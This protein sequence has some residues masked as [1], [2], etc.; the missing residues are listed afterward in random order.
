[1]PC[2][3]YGA[4]YLLDGLFQAG[5]AD[6]ALDLMATNGP[7]SWMN[8][9]NLSSTLTT[10][11]WSFADKPNEDWNHAWGAAA[12]NLIA[13]YVLGLQPLDAGFGRIR[14]QPHL[15]HNL[16]Y[17]RGVI[18]TIRGP[19]L[20]QVTNAPGLF[21]VWVSIPG[22]VTAKVMLPAHGFTNAGVLVDGSV[23]SGSLSNGWL[24]VTNIGSGQHAIWLNTNN[25]P[26]QAML[27]DNWTTG[28]FGTNAAN[29]V[30]AGLT[31]DPNGDG[32]ENFCEFIA[33]TNPLDAADRFQI[34]ETEYSS[35][36]PL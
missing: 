28:W 2:S 36:G 31:A 34:Q 35:A 18:P 15:G 10:E 6:T 20:I 29:A 26:S 13:R 5:D 22:N 24:T 21:R 8:M 25:V 3:V 12:G 27:Y 1:M 4:Q 17:V 23:V 30:I 16:S 9:I 33:G 32:V 14:I 7:R 19:V 11:A